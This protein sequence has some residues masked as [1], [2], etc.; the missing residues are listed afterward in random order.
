MLG[1]YQIYNR[2]SPRI[3]YAVGEFDWNILEDEQL[4]ISEFILPPFMLV[5]EQQKSGERINWYKA[6][7]LEPTQV[8]AAFQADPSRMPRRNGVG[9][10]QPAPGESN[11][12]LLKGFALTMALAVVITQLL[13]LLAKPERLLLQQQFSSQPTTLDN[14]VAATAAGSNNVIVTRSFE[15]QGP[16]A[17][18]FDVRSSLSNQWVEV[19]ITL[20]NER[21]GVSY[22]FTKSLEYYS[23]VED[24]ESW[25][26]GSRQDDAT[27][28]GIPSGRYHLNLYPTSDFGTSLLVDLTV[29]QN[30]PLHSNAVLALL[31]LLLYPGIQYFRRYNFEQTRWLS[32]DYGPQETD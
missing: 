21:T 6:E 20:V 4:V 5:Q 13:L 10:I 12:P 17:L 11:W 25:S 32:S 9:A 2:Y 28:A 26:E 14:A 19:P 8:E 27:L 3:L 22:E 31:L 15:V 29:S 16:A 24:G 1:T 30:T 18:E 7:H 23:G